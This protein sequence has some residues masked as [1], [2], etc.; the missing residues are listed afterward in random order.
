[1]TKFKYAFLGAIALLSAGIIA[2]HSIGVTNPAP[3]QQDATHLDSGTT[4]CSLA[5]AINATQ[6]AGTCTI[7]PPAGN[8]VYITALIIGQCQDGTVSVSGIQQNF[9]T[10]NLGG[11]VLETSFLS[12]ATI[13]TN[14]GTNLCGFVQLPLS[15]PLKS[16]A[17]GT[18]VTVVPPTQAAHASYPIT[19]VGYFAAY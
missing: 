10:T 17:A 5:G 3:V 18:V 16:A 7:T 2:A 8:Y 11:L 1:M 12:A 19:V 4:L 13:T 6:A 9:T 14:P 15:T